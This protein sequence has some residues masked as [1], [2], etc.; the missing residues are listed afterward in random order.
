MCSLVKRQISQMDQIGQHIIPVRKAHRVVLESSRIHRNRRSGQHL[1]DRLPQSVK[2]HVDQRHHN[3]ICSCLRPVALENIPQHNAHNRFRII[4]LLTAEQI[5]VIPPLHLC[6]IFAIF[7]TKFLYFRL[8][9]SNVRR[10]PACI[11]HGKLIK[12]IKGRLCLHLLNWKNSG[13]IGKTDILC[14]FCAFEQPAQKIDILFL[15][16]LPVRSIP[17]QHIPLIYDDNKFISGSFVHLRHC[18]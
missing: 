7:F 10:Q 16:L 3:L 8:R 2:I 9:K 11:Q 1:N 12:I 13:Q 15:L 4:D 14:R 5:T 6:E 17:D 18:F